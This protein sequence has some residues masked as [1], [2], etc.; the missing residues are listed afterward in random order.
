MMPTHL[1]N[2]IQDVLHRFLLSLVRDVVYI[3][4]DHDGLCQL[5]HFQRILP[6]GVACLE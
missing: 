3:V 5:I 2:V 4:E 6:E 1:Q